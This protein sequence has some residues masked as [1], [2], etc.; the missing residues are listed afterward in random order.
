MWSICSPG[1]HVPVSF[2]FFLNVKGL[3]CPIFYPYRK[4]SAGAAHISILIA[5][6]SL[7]YTVLW[8]TLYC[9]VLSLYA[10]S[11][12][13]IQH[14]S[15]LLNWCAVLVMFRS[16]VCAYHKQATFPQ[17]EPPNKNT[18]LWPTHHLRWLCS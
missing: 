10:Q 15:T 5:D 7:Y 18:T 17:P 13:K 1:Q 16:F 3:H 9:H 6:L 11:E 2:T 14:S 4:V 8:L 12:W